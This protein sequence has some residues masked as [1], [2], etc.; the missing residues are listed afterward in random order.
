MFE[1][2]TSFVKSH[3]IYFCCNYICVM[4]GKLEY[5]DT[6]QLTSAD[7]KDW[8]SSLILKYGEDSNQMLTKNMW[9]FF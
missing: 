8:K 3:W 2:K 7:I 5:I 6:K 1:H 9:Y 4:K